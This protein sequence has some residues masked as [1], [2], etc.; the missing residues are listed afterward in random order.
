M[1][2]PCWVKEARVWSISVV[3]M[4]LARATEV[5]LPRVSKLEAEVNLMIAVVEDQNKKNVEKEWMRLQFTAE[6]NVKMPKQKNGRSR[7]QLQRVT[8]SPLAR[9]TPRDHILGCT[10][11]LN[12]CAAFSPDG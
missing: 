4:G 10:Q 8:S 12:T 7:Q 5:R 3:L 9:S 2:R 6:E 11:G 1:Q